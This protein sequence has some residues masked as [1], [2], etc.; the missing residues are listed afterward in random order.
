MAS[1]KIPVGDKVYK[2]LCTLRMLM[3]LET[4]PQSNKYRQVLLKKKHYKGVTEA[5]S[6]GIVVDRTGNIETLALKLSDVVYTL[7]DLDQS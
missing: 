5:I 3:F 1:N 7:P 4:E 6:K 2:E